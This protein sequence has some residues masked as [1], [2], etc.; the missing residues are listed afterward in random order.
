VA[1]ADIRIDKSRSVLLGWCNMSIPIFSQIEKLIN[2]HGSAVILKERIALAQDQYAALEKKL[3]E[4]ESQ[5]KAAELRAKNL[6]SENRRLELDNDKLKE[7]IGSLEEQLSDHHSLRL[8]EVREKLL[9]A[10]SSG[11]RAVAAQLAQVIGVGEQLATFH[12]TEMEKDH[13]VSA[14]RFYT[15]K[16]TIWRIAQQGRGYLISHGLLK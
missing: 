15:N 7:I 2:E 13:L 8:E 12:L 16:P 11:D 10:L 5:T 6:E 1:G 9:I 4:S 3:S 14:A